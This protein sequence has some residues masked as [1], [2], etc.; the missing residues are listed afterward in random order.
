MDCI[1]DSA[2]TYGKGATLTKLTNRITGR[3]LFTPRN[4]FVG[5]TAAFKKQ[6]VSRRTKFK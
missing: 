1:G 3:Y 4:L 5:Q 2:T 6:Q